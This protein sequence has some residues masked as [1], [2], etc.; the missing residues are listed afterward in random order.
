TRRWSRWRNGG[1]EP[2]LLLTLDPPR[3]PGSRLRWSRHPGAVPLVDATH[4][5]AAPK[6]GHR[7]TATSVPTA[8]L[9]PDWSMDGPVRSDCDSRPASRCRVEMA[10]W[11]DAAVGAVEHSHQVGAARGSGPTDHRSASESRPPDRP[12]ERRGVWQEPP[13][14]HGDP[15]P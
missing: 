3:R 10:S 4:G 13:A 6:W 11:R 7:A 5:A 9:V 1:I 14:D 2:R 15:S 12:C 8:I